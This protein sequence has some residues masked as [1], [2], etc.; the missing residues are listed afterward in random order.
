MLPTALLLAPGAGANRSHPALLALDDAVDLPTSRIDIKVR[1]HDKVM[2]LI[3]KAA[4]DLVE[5]AKTQPA[6]LVLGGRSFGGRMCS[7][8]VA[9]GLP[10]RGLIL[11]SYPL[12]PPGKPEKLRVDHFD[13]LELPVL[14]VSGTNDA[15][16]SPAEFEHHQ[17]KIP[18]A[19]TQVWIDGADHTMRAKQ[20]QV[21]AA[22]TNWLATLT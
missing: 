2:S 20:A 4:N 7:L 13:R 5:R 6:G 16:G 17:A 1:N 11:L 8:A 19:V 22:V 3:S 15:F 12:H 9:E 21:V 18:G 14:F 10:A